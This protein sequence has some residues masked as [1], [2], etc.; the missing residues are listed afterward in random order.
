MTTRLAY[1][2]HA[3]AIMV[4]ARV[5]PSKQFFKDL[6]SPRREI[7]ASFE[8]RRPTDKPARETTVFLF[9]QER[10]ARDWTLKHRS[11][12]LIEVEVDE[13][14][15]GHR[16]DWRWFDRAM[17]LGLDDIDGIRAA[18]DAYWRGEPCGDPAGGIWE[19]LVG[20][21]RMVREMI[22]PSDEREAAERRRFGITA[23]DIAA[24]FH[25][26]GEAP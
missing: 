22:I 6:A 20:E 24:G 13:A 3:G 10:D 7:E 12:A 4:G 15:I 1:R 17:A 16:G 25:L 26:G 11:R 19:L 21:A 9:E 8:E 23:A 18:A 2:A 5:P 14:Q